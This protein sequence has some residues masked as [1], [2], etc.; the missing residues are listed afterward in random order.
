MPPTLRITRYSRRTATLHRL[1]VAGSAMACCGAERLMASDHRR[2]AVS[3]ATV[4][5]VPLRNHEPKV[6]WLT[7]LKAWHP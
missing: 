2:W 6:P 4:S 3:K 5:S 1:L 7:S